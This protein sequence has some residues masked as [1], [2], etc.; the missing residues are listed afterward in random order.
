MA[1]LAG[2]LQSIIPVTEMYNY[3]NIL[4]NTY[5]GSGC[6]C[7]RRDFFDSKKIAVRHA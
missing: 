6:D 1:K 4:D 3:E 7:S 2:H 5:I